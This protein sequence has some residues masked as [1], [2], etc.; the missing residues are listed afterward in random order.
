MEPIKIGITHGDMNGIGYEV[1]IKSLNDARM[2]DICTPVIYG[3]SKA[4]A[5]YRKAL[6]FDE[7]GAIN[8]VK[9]A[10]EALKG[11]INIVNCST[12]DL[13][14]ET[15]VATQESARAAFAAL[16]MA[17]Q[18]ALEGRIDALVTCP[19][20]KESMQEAGFKFPGH[21][22]YLENKTSSNKS[23]MFFVS[24]KM[25]VALVTNHVPIAQVAA[26]ITRE[27]ILEKLSMLN[28]S[29]KQDFGIISPRIA[30]LGLN[31]HCGDGGVIGRE[32]DEI[33]A[34]AIKTASEKGIM[35]FGPISADGFFASAG[36]FKF[37]AVLA[38]YHDQA[39]SPFKALCR[40]EEGVNYTAALPI[41]RTSP[42]HG[43]AYELAGTGK[44]QEGSFRSAIYLA[45]DV[46]RS[47]R[48]QKELK[49]NPLPLKSF[50]L[51]SED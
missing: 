22:E 35:C 34:P 19:I 33:I 20:N 37:D 49:N 25:K 18:D 16:E 13:K 8:V 48:K 50:K 24:E 43:T 23:L 29:L 12:D 40:G 21:T 14:V 47:R 27:K 30:V 32:D 42:I 28:S 3:L 17:L 1:L 7:G 4:W 36:Y 6:G 11:R 26:N 15:G 38:M 46:V 2:L 31:P 9:S 10:S 41:V 39:L 44:A 5:F 45:I 51:H